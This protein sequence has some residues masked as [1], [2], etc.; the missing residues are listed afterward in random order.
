MG[1]FKPTYRVHA[2][3]DLSVDELAA[4]G[5][6]C[7]LVDRD[8]TCVPRDTGVVPPTV[9]AWLARARAAGMATCVV[10]NNFHGSQVE[11]SA[12]ELGCACVHH[13]MKP[14]PFAVRR[15]LR[16]MGAVPSEAILIGDQVFTDV[17]AG[18]LA[19]V[20]TALVDPQ[21]TTDLWYTHVLRV[22]ERLVDP[23]VPDGSSDGGGPR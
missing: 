16:L 7:V 20:R 10:S 19:G 15:A 8:N 6:R 12:R 2:I 21:S 14:A 17:V 1:L 23:G 18:H 22:V 4:A 3:T 11:S 5:V 9:L 13:A